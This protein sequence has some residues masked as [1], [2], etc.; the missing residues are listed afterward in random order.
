MRYNGI[1]NTKQHIALGTG[2][3]TFLT[4]TAITNSVLKKVNTF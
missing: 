2:L 1:A 3:L 4:T